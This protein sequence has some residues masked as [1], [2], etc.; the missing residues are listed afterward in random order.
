MC[1]ETAVPIIH[2]SQGWQA[3]LPK[4][5]SLDFLMQAH[6]CSARLAHLRC[7]H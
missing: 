3:W 2:L 7:M 6:I 1:T 4:L 5:W